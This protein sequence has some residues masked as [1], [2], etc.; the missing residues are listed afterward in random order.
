MAGA[1]AAILDAVKSALSIEE[2]EVLPPGPGE[3]QVKYVASGV[4]HSDLH[5][6]TGDMLHPLPV[7]LGHEGGG[8]VE[9]VGSGV[10]TCQV[11]DH[12]LTSYI[13][14]CGTCSYC[15]IG[16]P[17]L[18]ALRDR[19]RH[20]ML[21]GTSRFRR[22]DGSF[23][24]HFLQVSS[25]AT[26]AVLLQEGVIPIRKD[27][28]LDVVCLV[29]CGVTAGMGAVLNRAKVKPGSTVVVFGCG[30]VG[31]NVIQAAELAGAGRVIAVDRLPYKLGLAEEFGATHL[32]DASKEDPVKRV[33][34]ITGGVGADYAFEAIGAPRVIETML[35]CLHRGGEAYIIG[36]SPHGARISI[37][38]SL[39]VQERVLSGSSFGGSRQRV[40]LPMI[41]DLFM[42]GK[43]KLRELVSRRLGLDDVN[44]AFELLN[45]GEVARSVLVYT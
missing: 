10:T 30:G 17:N 12:V 1:R 9:A 8:I 16:R 36:V 18:C 32:I 23:V 7:I 44:R 42:Q 39:L 19:P 15:T 21:D 24:N 38:P 27:A 33:H 31:L 35:E 3:V 14:S 43:V 4:C 11:G 40:D 13:P 45:R 6:I 22:R 26:R 34:E 28:P 25:F 2:I 5:A 41:V 29:S 20:L 37:D